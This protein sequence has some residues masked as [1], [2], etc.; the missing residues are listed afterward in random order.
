MQLF[1]KRLQSRALENPIRGHI[2]PFCAKA[3]SPG[4]GAG[5]EC[6]DVPARVVIAV[7]YRDFDHSF[8]L[9]ERKVVAVAPREVDTVVQFSL[10]SETAPVACHVIR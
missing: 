4:R 1:L 9:C 2:A 5:G 6:G 10:A 3:E 7:V 8:G